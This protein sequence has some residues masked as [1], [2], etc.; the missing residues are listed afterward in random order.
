MTLLSKEILSKYKSIRRNNLEIEWVQEFFRE[1]VKNIWEGFS[2]ENVGIIE[3]YY[4]DLKKYHKILKDY[5]LNLSI[6]ETKLI[7]LWQNIDEFIEFINNNNWKI[8]DLF[9]LDKEVI[10]YLFSEDWV[11]KD[12]NDLKKFINHSGFKDF[13]LFYMNAYDISIV[14]LLFWKNWVIKSVDE[15]GY[16]YKSWLYW[17]ITSWRLTITVLKWYIYWFSYNNIWGNLNSLFSVQSNWSVLLM[18]IKKLMEEYPEKEIYE[19][20]REKSNYYIENNKIENQEKWEKEIAIYLRYWRTVN[21]PEIWEAIIIFLQETIKKWIVKWV[22]GIKILPKTLYITPRSNILDKNTRFCNVSWKEFKYELNNNS[23]P[24]YLSHSTNEAKWLAILSWSME[25]KKWQINLWLEL[26][27]GYDKDDTNNKSI[28]EIF[29]ILMW[30][31]R[32]IN[33]KKD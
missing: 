28:N 25:T 8:K 14:K 11:I 5:W 21:Y 3:A 19:I 26:E 17:Y 2:V 6:E 29:D 12:K 1:Y 16:I 10:E 18:E 22:K 9:N 24:F 31:I 30:I 4:D 15:M 7:I 32:K 20:L 13:I 33:E 23:I 27:K